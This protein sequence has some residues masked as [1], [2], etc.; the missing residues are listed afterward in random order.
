MTKAEVK[1]IH[2]LI[3]QAIE[4]GDDYLVKLDTSIHVE[5]KTRE[6]LSAGP[7]C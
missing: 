3:L 7:N 2:H 6:A 1:L 4:K 5:R